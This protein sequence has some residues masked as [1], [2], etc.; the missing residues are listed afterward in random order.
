MVKFSEVR[1]VSYCSFCSAGKKTEATDT[2]D[3]CGE[4]L[5]GN[6]MITVALPRKDSL[7]RLR[8]LGIRATSDMLGYRIVPICPMC[9]HESL[10]SLTKS[11]GEREYGEVP[12]RG[13]GR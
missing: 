7:G 1:I 2:C 13:L 4:D 3:N 12:V 8:A 9:A 6:H 11:L 5:C 10:D